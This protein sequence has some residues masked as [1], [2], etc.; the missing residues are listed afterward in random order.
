MSFSALKFFGFLSLLLPRGFRA[1][2]NF[3]F[4][5]MFFFSLIIFFPL[6]VRYYRRRYRPYNKKKWS[7]ETKAITIQTSN[8]Q[9]EQVSH[10]EIPI[11][12]ATATEGKR[13]VKNINVQMTVPYSY[14]WALIYVPQGAERGQLL[15]RPPSSA[16]SI[17][18]PNQYVMAAGANDVSAGPNRIFCPLART[19]NSG[20]RIFFM[21]SGIDTTVINTIGIIRYAV[22]YS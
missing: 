19:L 4:F 20:D 6:M 7:V 1:Y 17:Y 21:M 16:V 10:A 22:C 15:Q 3:Y 2:P 11:I 14:R 8:E 13:T 12:E 5:R 9:G 18:E